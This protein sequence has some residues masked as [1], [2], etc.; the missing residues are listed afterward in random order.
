LGPYRVGTPMGGGAIASA[1]AYT[2]EIRR[3]AARLAVVALATVGAVGLLAWHQSH[4]RQ[5]R[6]SVALRTYAALAAIDALERSAI[7]HAKDGASGALAEDPRAVQAMERLRDLEA[8]AGDAAFAAP[9]ARAEAAWHDLRAG[10]DAAAVL[11]AVEALEQKHAAAAESLRGDGD[12]DRGLPWDTILPIVALVGM[13][14]LAA[15]R[16]ARRIV[17]AT[18][19]QRAVEDALRADEAGHARAQAIAALGHWSWDMGTGKVT[20][21]AETY[22]ILGRTP[23]TLPDSFGAFLEVVHPDDRDLFRERVRKARDSRRPYEC[24]F[25]VVRPDGTVRH[26]HS[27][28]EV[29]VDAATGDPTAMLGTVLDITDRKAA[30]EAVETSERRFRQI[31]DN[32]AFGIGMGDTQDRVIEVNAAFA[33]FTGYAP[34]ELRGRHFADLCHPDDLPAYRALVEQTR[35]GATGTIERRYLRKDGTTA[36]GRLTL[37]PLRDGHEP[38]EYAIGLVEDISARRAMEA[39]L[40]ERE[41]LLSQVTENIDEVFWLKDASG[42]RLLYVSP[43]FE[44][45]FGRTMASLY[46]DAHSWHAAVHPD[47]RA[48]LL[49]VLTHGRE[50][51]TPYAAHYRI[52]RPDG[53]ERVIH[54]RGYPVRDAEGKVFRWAGVAADVTELHRLQSALTASEQRLRH[55]T[56]VM[57]EVFWM[58]DERCERTFYISPSYERVW[59]RSCE[60]L[61]ENPMSWSD[62]VH[63]D[64]RERVR[65][66]FLR[67]RAEGRPYVVTYRIVRPD[68]TERVI[69]SRAH[70]MGDAEPG[71]PPQWVG[72]SSDIT[73][74]HRVESALLEKEERLRE[75]TENIGEVFWIADVEAGR[76]TYVSPA[77]ET[78]W[79]RRCEEVY[80]DPQAWFAAIHPD[81]RAGLA[82]AIEAATRA[83]EP[84]EAHYRIVRPDGA[85]R[86]IRDRGHP[87]RDADGKVR[88]HVGVAADVTEQR[89]AEEDRRRYQEELAHVT[90]LAT[91]GQ[92]ASELAHEINQPLSAIANYAQGSIRRLAAG[93]GPADDGL[94]KSLEQIAGQAARAGAIVRHLRELV[95]KGRG[96]R[97]VED[98]NAL[99][100][101]AAGLLEPEARRHGVRLRLDLGQG[102]DPVAVDR[103]Q[104]DQVVINLTTNAIEAL[105]ERPGTREVVLS[106]RGGGG[107]P[108]MVAVADNGPGLPEEDREGLFGPF[109]TTKPHGLGMGLAIGRSIIEAHGGELVAEP[110]PNGGAVFR[111]TVPQ[112][113]AH[114]A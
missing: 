45:I 14:G 78:V 25:R 22:R 38:H 64:D 105:A 108:V 104:V 109:Y 26:V 17:R 98:M 18:D 30:E 81:D 53:T 44:T 51:G 97:T 32:A 48:R 80:R 91:M 7:E 29:S 73:E 90:R 19:G 72:V 57:G 39:A 71:A 60:S 6:E 52:V 101:A 88:R 58:E 24:E 15:H 41:E 35:A 63:L 27:R 87:V 49:A 2:R 12:P 79:G 89:A 113:G 43:A 62:A 37:A 114:D 99:V 95:V 67:A 40:N 46:A 36:W 47:D 56:E 74:F 111:F 65:A 68:G 61:Y 85:E 70:P 107:R 9:M 55:V 94:L 23:E 82:A 4:T 33:R 11:R 31:F 10:G 69:R 86:H 21:S 42:N 20:R 100:T 13:G 3:N 59:G 28:A 83:G 16:L 66:A 50:A 1:H 76:V 112:A 84:F 93:G 106:T 75:V 102:L 34:A 92:M 54:G 96:R 8:N 110:G 77:Y 103:I 5:V